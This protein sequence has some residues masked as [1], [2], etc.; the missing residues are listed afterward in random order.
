LKPLNRKR[1]NSII[2]GNNCRTACKKIRAQ[3]LWLYLQLIQ[4][5]YN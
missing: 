3:A 2:T 1:R 4:S 5:L